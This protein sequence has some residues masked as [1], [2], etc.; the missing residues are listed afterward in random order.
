MQ[1]KLSPAV[2]A[3]AVAASAACVPAVA[4]AE[5][6]FNIGMVSLYKSSG[7]DEDDRGDT[8]LRPALQGGVNYSFGNGFYV[9][10]WNS[11]GKFANGIGEIDLYVGYGGDITKGLSYDLKLLTY[12][13]PGS[14][15]GQNGSEFAAK[16]SYGIAS[17]RYVHGLSDYKDSNEWVLGVSVPVTEKL[18]LLADYHM[19]K[20]ASTAKSFVLGASYDLGDGLSA[21]ARV[22]GTD[23][24]T[25]SGK[26]RLVLGVSKSF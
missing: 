26:T 13:Y 3:M 17:V 23:D 14:D 1:F 22:S 12:I 4:Q 18:S 2:A 21:S 19:R 16:L 5:L 10:N 11:T 20:K 24:D 25:T 9:G 6:S 8:N 15:D 7:K